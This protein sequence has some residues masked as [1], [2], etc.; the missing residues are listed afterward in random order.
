MLAF[1]K[2]EGIVEVTG[3]EMLDI[4]TVNG[5]DV[6]SDGDL[7]GSLTA[8]S[9]SCCSELD[10]PLSHLDEIEED[11]ASGEFALLDLTFSLC[12]YSNR[13]SSEW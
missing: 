5:F 2:K 7:G 1:C 8:F 12:T 10:F 3:L 9:N 4:L 6:M 11:D 13:S